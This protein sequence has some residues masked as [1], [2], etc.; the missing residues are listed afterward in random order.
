M[1][2]I[3]LTTV[4]AAFAPAFAQDAASGDA[5]EDVIIVTAQKRAQDIQDVPLAITA[6]DQERQDAF[7][8][9]QFDDLADFVPGLEVQEQSA[10][11]PGFVIRGITSDSGEAN[12]EPR[13]AIFQDGVPISRSRGSFV[14]LFDS[15]VEVVRGPQPTLFGRSALIGAINIRA[16]APELGTWG[17]KARIGAGNEEFFFAEGVLNAPI[18]DTAAVRFAGRYKQRDGYTGNLIGEDLNGFET[19]ALRASVLWEPNDRFSLTVIGN[20]QEDDNPGTS[21][22]SGTFLPVAEDGSIGELNPSAPAAL[23]A[24]G[25][26]NGGQA[27]GLEREV[28]G[29]TGLVSFDLTDSLTLSSVTNWREFDSAE[30]F[31]PDGFGLPFLAFAENATG[32]QFFQ[33]IRLDFDNARGFSGFVGASYFD[34]E[35]EQNVPLFT[36]ERIAQ[37][38]FAG[39]LTFPPFGNPNPAGEGLIPAPLAAF[40]P[41]LLNPFTGDPVITPDGTVPLGV[42]GENFSN[43]GETQSVDLFADVTY[44]VTER[45]DVTAGFRYTLDDKKSGFAS[46]LL[47]APSALTGAGLVLGGTVANGFNP[48]FAEEEYD[49]FTWRF[50]GSYDL[51]DDVTMFANYGRGRRPEVLAYSNDTSVVGLDP[52]LFVEIDAETTDAFD[53]GLRGSFLGGALN[54][55]LV[56]YYYDYT[57]FQ[58]TTVNDQ[59]QF[60]PINAGNASGPGFESTVEIVGAPWARYFFTYAYNGVEFD[61][62]LENGDPS[63]RA[64]NRFRLAPEHA[65]TAAAQLSFECLCGTFT[66]T[67]IYSY[68]SEIFFDDDND[69]PELQPATLIRPLGDTAVDELQEGYG[70]V[71]LRLTY[72]PDF[73]DSWKL[74][75]FVENLFDEEFLLD[76]GNTGDG[77]GIPTFIAGPPR[78]FGGYISK[79]F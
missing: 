45:F 4:F 65:F 17:G 10:N 44:A 26:V 23:S 40:P 15:Q 3:L 46:G 12:I 28:Y 58:T 19:T 53:L 27:L 70:L 37:I 32:E 39:A 18:G 5:P 43:F 61:D 36:D 79:S 77:F 56:G 69:R 25:G 66:F 64:G 11:N 67:P 74:E 31:D 8:I 55:E 49:G 29:I 42:V 24:F 13:V 21:F 14:E 16:A 6:L 41:V 7:G 2:K 75:L 57:N 59:G 1:K 34:E 73:D 72:V 71:D 48:I 20:Y 52:A 50:A 33:E 47:T 22:K 54:T 9:Q 62:E 78:L 38:A 63:P 60:E 76:A 30:V 68:K 35:G 51:T